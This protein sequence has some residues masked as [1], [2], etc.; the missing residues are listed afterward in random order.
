MKSVKKEL[1]DTV[2]DLVSNLIITQVK[3]TLYNQEEVE[4]KR[5]R[6]FIEVKHRVK[7]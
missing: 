6:M 1:Y 7:K 5:N 4:L 3:N 2:R